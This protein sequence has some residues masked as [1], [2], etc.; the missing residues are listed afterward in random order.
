MPPPAAYISAIVLVFA[1]KSPAERWFFVANYEEVDAQSNGHSRNH[2]SPVGVPKNNPEPNPAQREAQVH[3]I[4]YV[5]IEAHDHQAL[6]GSGGSWC[7]S[8]GPRKIPDAAQSNRES[9]NRRQRG[10][11]APL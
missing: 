7:A 6:R 5:A 3:G 2:R 11:P 8:P 10:E 9:Q 1:I 4:S